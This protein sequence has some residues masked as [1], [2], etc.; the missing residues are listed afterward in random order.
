MYEQGESKRQD[1][2]NWHKQW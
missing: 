2:N 1:L